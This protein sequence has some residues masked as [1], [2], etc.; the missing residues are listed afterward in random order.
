MSATEPACATDGLVKSM[1][2]LTVDD[3]GPTTPVDLDELDDDVDEYLNGL[4]IR[5]FRTYAAALTTVRQRTGSI[6]LF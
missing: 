5:R 3:L 1:S 6:G 2:D 4:T